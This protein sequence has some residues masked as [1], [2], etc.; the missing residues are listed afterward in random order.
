MRDV[1]ASVFQKIDGKMVWV[2]DFNSSQPKQLHS[3]QPGEYIVVHRTKS[4]T[5]TLYTKKKEFKVQSG[6]NTQLSL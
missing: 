2:M 3:I 4:E 6:L 1:T 5:R